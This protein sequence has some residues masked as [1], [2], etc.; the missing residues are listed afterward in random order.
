M[1][2]DFPERSIGYYRGPVD[3]VLTGIQHAHIEGA[4]LEVDAAGGD[5]FD[6]FLEAQTSTHPE[7]HERN[8]RRREGKWRIGPFVIGGDSAMLV[9]I[10]AVAA[11][12]ELLARGPFTLVMHLAVIDD[13]GYLVDAPD[14]GD[15]EIWV[16]DR[17]P[18]ESIEALRAA[19]GDRLRPDAD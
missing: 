3:P 13:E 11:F 16:S 19:L 18:A 1:E 8:R 2:E 7:V 17:L 5:E 14:V 10:D 9:P 6:R 12:R 15:N 4:L